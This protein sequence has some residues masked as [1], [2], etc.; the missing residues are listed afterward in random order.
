MNVLP[1]TLLREGNLVQEY[2]NPSDSEGT[3]ML[4]PVM[5]RDR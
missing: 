1:P 3:A 2:L 5:W 4:M